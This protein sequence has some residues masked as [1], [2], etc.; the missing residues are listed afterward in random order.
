MRMIKTLSDS[1]R[2]NIREAR[3]HI[4]KAYALR[5]E[6]RVAADWY[7]SMAAT[8]LDFN[9]AGHA[10][11]KKLIDEHKASGKHTDFDAGMLA[12]YEATHTDLI[13]DAAEVRYLIDQF[14]K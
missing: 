2:E 8:H 6:C 5:D 13:R 7:K 4:D 1:I 3:R 9:N 11:V 12:V 14:P 10:A